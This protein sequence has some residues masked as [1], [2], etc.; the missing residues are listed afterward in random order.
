MRM[1]DAYVHTVTQNYIRFSGRMSRAEFWWFA[2]CNF[3][4]IFAL[5]ILAGLLT[6]GL[7]N[8]GSFMATL[9]EAIYGIYL[10]AMLLPSIGAE[11]RRLHDIDLSGWLV[12]LNLIPYLGGLIVLI[13][14]L[15]PAKPSG[16]KYGPYHDSTLS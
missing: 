8:Q 14:M 5:V 3:L 12:L 1:L 7:Q 10:L 6:G 16:D 11:V 2:L 13:L 4:I 15:L 9:F